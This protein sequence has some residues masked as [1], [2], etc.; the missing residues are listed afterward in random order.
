MN[1]LICG[2]HTVISAY[3]NNRAKK[4]YIKNKD[5][6]NLFKNIK[7]EEKELSFFKKK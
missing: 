3:K 6:I 2:K 1:Y 4:I 5:D 7:I